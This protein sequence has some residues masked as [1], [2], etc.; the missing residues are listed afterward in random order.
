MKRSELRKT[1]AGQ[2]ETDLIRI[3]DLTVPSKLKVS[4]KGTAMNA[5]I[6]KNERDGT[7]QKLYCSD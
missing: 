2:G 7:N 1:T 5:R 4:W 3:V 6:E